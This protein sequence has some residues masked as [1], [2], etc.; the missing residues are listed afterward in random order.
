MAPIS[1]SWLP[2]ASPPPPPSQ[3]FLDSR[4]RC[5]FS[6]V[7]GDPSHSGFH[8][9]LEDKGNAKRSLALFFLH[10]WVVVFVRVAPKPRILPGRDPE[11]QLLKASEGLCFRAGMGGGRNPSGTPRPL[12]RGHRGRF[13]PPPPE[14]NRTWQTY[15]SADGEHGRSLGQGR[16]D[17]LHT[18]CTLWQV[19][20]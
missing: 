19:E 13:V 2:K 7:S 10:L 9:P 6:P 15:P 3:P 5:Q 11:K 12:E 14:R 1:A 18:G 4:T 16:R 20:A 17:G 8:S